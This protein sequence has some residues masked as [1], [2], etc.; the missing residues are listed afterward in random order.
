MTLR[1]LLK[2][3]STLHPDKDMECYTKTLVILAEVLK[4]IHEKVKKK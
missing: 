1:K 2:I 3:Y 4:K